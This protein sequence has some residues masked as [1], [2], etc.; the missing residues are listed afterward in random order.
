M[1]KILITGITGLLGSALQEILKEEGY[2]V[3]D[4]DVDITDGNAVKSVASEGSMDWII[5]TAAMTN[6]NQCE[7]EQT[8]C[9]DVNVE[10]AKNVRDLAKKLGAKLLYISTVSVFSGK[11]G[12]YKETDVPQPVNFYNHTK[13]EGEKAVLEYE[14]SLVLRINLIGVHPNGS[15]GQNFFEWLLD[16][17]KANKDIKLFSDVMINP[18]SNWTIAEFIGKIIEQNPEEKILHLGSSNVL[19]KT[20]IGKYVI[21]KLAY[22]GK[23]EFVSVDSQSGAERPKQ[24]WLNC[25]YTCQKMGWRMPKLEFEID[26]ILSK[27]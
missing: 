3:Y 18:L 8:T 6:V 14:K 20:D 16:S 5:H 15:R 1:K 26:K 19:S 9:Y 25:E 22:Q 23:A 10:G 13:R 21:K 7:K 2:D 17:K 24:M 27:I 12:N 11:E 4:I